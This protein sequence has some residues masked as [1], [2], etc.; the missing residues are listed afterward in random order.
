MWDDQTG[1]N[2]RGGNTF[3][4]SGFGNHMSGEYLQ[5]KL[6]AGVSNECKQYKCGDADSAIF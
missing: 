6:R 3:Q 1:F 2:E 4:S 5:V